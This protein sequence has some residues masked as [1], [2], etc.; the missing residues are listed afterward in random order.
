MA[1][2][3]VIHLTREVRLALTSATGERAPTI[4]EAQNSWAGGPAADGLGPFLHLRLTIEGH[5]EPATGYI[6]D[7]K[8]IDRI[9][10]RAA[11]IAL[12]GLPPGQACHLPPSAFLS[13]V[14]Q[15][16][17]VASF[18]GVTV[19]EL[20]VL[21]SPYVRYT[22]RRDQPE[23]IEYTEQFEF[24]AAHRLHNSALSDQENRAIFGK[25]NNPRGHGH[26]YVVEV[27]VAGD[28]EPPPGLSFRGR[29]V[30]VVQSQVLNRFDH[31]HLNEDT[32]E[33][34]HLNPTVENITRVIWDLL[35][36][37]LPPIRLVAV[38]VYETPKTWA[39]YRE[40]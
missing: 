26:N 25:C 5:P 40:K 36:E 18:P 6:C 4:A 13:A 19:L 22:L 8:D 30:K 11:L 14:W 1:P 35:A 7:I 32:A 34:H 24:A 10:R 9:L 16:L 28:G 15:Q 3:G 37:A 31:K 27:S 12:D 21:P 17:L 2:A 23:M 38:R 20:Q 29:L 33:F 39:E